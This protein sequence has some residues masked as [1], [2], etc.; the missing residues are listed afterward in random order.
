MFSFFFYIL[1]F[2]F[3]LMLLDV[4]NYQSFLFCYISS[5]CLHS[6]PHSLKCDIKD[7]LS[8]LLK[9]TILIFFAAS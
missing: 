3:L 8:V 7:G 1:D 4:W 9:N 6:G 5:L 2:R